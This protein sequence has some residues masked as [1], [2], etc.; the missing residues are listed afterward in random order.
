MALVLDATVG[1]PASNSYA[2]VA[3]GDLYHE[4]RLHSEAWLEATLET[5]T[6]ALVWATRQLDN[7]YEWEGVKA[8]QTQALR[9]PRIGAYDHDG[10]PIASDVLPIDLRDATSELA[11]LLI[12]GDRGEESDS[13]GVTSVSVGPVSV[14]FDKW[15]RSSTVPDS[16]SSM[17]VYLGSLRGGRLTIEVNRT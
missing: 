16:V 17:L 12:E 13:R 15:D 14:D 1:G 9:W 6:T 8:T 3:E 10:Y 11:R 2:T 5:K 7:W 4:A